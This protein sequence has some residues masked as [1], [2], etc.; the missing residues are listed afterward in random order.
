MNKKFLLAY[1]LLAAGTVI[2][3]N[4]NRTNESFWHTEAALGITVPLKK[5]YVGQRE[6]KGFSVQLEGLYRARMEN[7]L[8]LFAG[9]AAGPF[10][11]EGFKVNDS[12]SL[13]VNV[14]FWGGVGYNF[15]K[16]KQRQSL[17]LAGLLGF[18]AFTFTDYEHKGGY[19]YRKDNTAF[20]FELGAELLHTIQITDRLCFYSGCSFFAGLGWTISEA[21]REKTFMESERRESKA[22]DSCRLLSLQ[23]K[24]GLMYKIN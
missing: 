13:C 4:D 12:H 1:L 20:C 19:R 3:A 8:S 5:I 7:G 6:S 24:I 17:V 9:A 16:N 15:L 22:R 10:I 18:D 2:F 11:S 23:P 14:N 21:T